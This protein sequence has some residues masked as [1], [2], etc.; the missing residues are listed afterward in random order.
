MHYAGSC[1][2]IVVFSL[3]LL[4]CTDRRPA[5]AS[6]NTDTTRLVQPKQDVSK[7][8]EKAQRYAKY[9]LH[10]DN[11]SRS[12]AQIEQE[13]SWDP[14]ALSRTGAMGHAQIMPQTL[15]WGAKTFARHLGKPDA[16][17]P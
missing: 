3:A 14:Y 11:P 16:N 1:V 2:C 13:S 9:Y 7:I 12:M 4:A 6:E 15:E 10:H 17:N 5:E 8:P